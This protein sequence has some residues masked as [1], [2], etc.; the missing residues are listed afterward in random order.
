MC[1]IYY[2]FYIHIQGWSQSH[3][4]ATF[5]VFKKKKSGN[6]RVACWD[7]VSDEVSPGCMLE[8]FTVWVTV[9]Q[10]LYSLLFMRCS[11]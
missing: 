11:V 2:L 3:S 6:H 9:L 1:F 5:N 7:V 4:S 10:N 8:I